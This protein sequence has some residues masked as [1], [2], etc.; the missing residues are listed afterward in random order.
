M[1]GTIVN[2]LTIIVGSFL[3]YFM[4]N[5]IKEE[6]KTTIMDGLGLTVLIIGI[7]GSIKTENILLVIASIVIG[8]IMGEMIGIEKRL[9]NMALGLEKRFGKGDSNFSKGF[10]TATLV[11]CVGAMAIVGSL[12]AGLTGNYQTLF[13]KS[14]LDG[15]AALI[16]ASTMGI[17]VVFSVIPLFI[18]QGGIT[19]LSTVLKDV[20]TPLVINEMSAVGGV[21]ILAIGIN[22][23]GIKKIK[24]GN[25]LPALLVPIVFSFIKSLVGF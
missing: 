6:Y 24:I 25:M 18:Y 11:F 22:L 5:G 15:V 9:D 4:R 8:S 3:G 14:I 7:S 12:E 16:F 20:F 23:L 21:L 19:L 13:A 1:L 10:I 17:G 2:V